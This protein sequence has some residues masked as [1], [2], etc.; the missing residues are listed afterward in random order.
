LV[1]FERGRDRSLDVE[2]HRSS[3]ALEQL[4]RS[5]FDEFRVYGGVGGGVGNEEEL[6]Q[7]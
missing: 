4:H 7:E 6:W 5:V 3:A 1:T 2:T